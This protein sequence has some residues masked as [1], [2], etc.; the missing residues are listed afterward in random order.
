[1]PK[2]KKNS[3]SNVQKGKKKTKIITLK[4]IILYI[5][6]TE[7]SLLLLITTINQF[8]KYNKYKN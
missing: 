8:K 7:I 2:K 5:E 4:F 1:M 3:A 6:F